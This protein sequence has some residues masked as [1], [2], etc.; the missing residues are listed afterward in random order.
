MIQRGQF[1]LVGTVLVNSALLVVL[2]SLVF[3]DKFVWSKLLFMLAATLWFLGV[4]VIVVR[5]L[6][7][8]APEYLFLASK[9]IEALSLVGPDKVQIR[10]AYAWFKGRAWSWQMSDSFKEVAHQYFLDNRPAVRD[11]V[12]PPE[13]VKVYQA[14][15]V[16]REMDESDQK[17]FW[18]NVDRARAE[19]EEGVRK[20]VEEMNQRRPIILPS[21]PI[22]GLLSG[23][24]VRPSLPALPLP[25]TRGNAESKVISFCGAIVVPKVGRRKKRFFEVFRSEKEARKYKGEGERVRPVIVFSVPKDARRRRLDGGKAAIDVPSAD[26]GPAN[27]E[28]NHG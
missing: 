5:V 20:R 12:P 10:T 24:V 15:F 26:P 28:A 27:D 6:Q 19:F 18:K 22:P 8:H 11:G 16:S 23:S 17:A 21:A 2:S 25:S 1:I 4:E 14:A 13:D 9:N 3:S 7:A